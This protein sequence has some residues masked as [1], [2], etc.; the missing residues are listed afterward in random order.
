LARPGPVDPGPATRRSP[1]SSPPRSGSRRGP[2]FPLSG[3]GDRVIGKPFHGV[4]CPHKRDCVC[5]FSHPATLTCFPFL[6]PL[7]KIRGFP[8][9]VSPYPL[10]L[11]YITLWCCGAVLPCSTQ[12]NF[13]EHH[14]PNISCVVLL[15][16][17]IHTRYKTW[18]PTVTVTTPLRALLS[19]M[20]NDLNHVN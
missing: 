9:P 4:H 11:D 15:L 8:K 7:F 3:R 2:R 5:E 10:P 18:K 17:P 1:T 14:Y 12:R 16:G 13:I 6:C 20:L 19:D